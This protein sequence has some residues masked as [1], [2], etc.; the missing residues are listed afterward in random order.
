MAAAAEDKHFAFGNLS[1]NELMH[2][3]RRLSD[4]SR[5]PTEDLAY[6]VR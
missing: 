1:V 4:A 5:V 6:L 2:A 3:A